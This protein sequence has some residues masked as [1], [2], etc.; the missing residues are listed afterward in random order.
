MFDFFKFLR[1]VLFNE[2]EK[3]PIECHINES[4]QSLGIKGML[5]AFDIENLYLRRINSMRVEQEEFKTYYAELL[6]KRD[7]ARAV[8]LLNKEQIVR[9]RINEKLPEIEAEVEKELLEEADKPFA[10]KIELC[11]R[12]IKEDEPVVEDSAE[13]LE[14]NVEV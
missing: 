5:N 13:N 1:K 7:E 8:A 10:E 3:P 11:E 14:E 12:F 2:K 9:D 4:P 6:A